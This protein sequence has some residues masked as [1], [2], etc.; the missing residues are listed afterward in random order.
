MNERVA[1]RGSQDPK[2]AAATAAGAE[3][4]AF[5]QIRESAQ[6]LRT[7]G[8]SDEACELL[9]SALEAVLAKSRDLELLVAKLRRQPIGRKSER[10]DPAQLQL[11]FMKMAELP[12]PPKASVDPEAEA[13]EDALLD[14]EIEQAEAKRPKSPGKQ[15]KKGAGWEA[16]GIERQ[17]HRVGVPAADRKCS[18]CG[19][20]MKPL[21][22]DVTRRLEYMPGH[23]IE[24]ETHLETLA[25]PRCKE[26]VITAPAPPQVLERSAVGASVLADMIVGKFIDHRPLHQ[27]SRGYARLGVDI[28]VSTLADW[29]A[30]AGERIAPLVEHLKA[31]VLAATFVRTDATGLLVLDPASPDHVVRGS[32]W[33]YVGDDRDVLFQYTP[34]GKGETGPWTFLAGRKGYIQAD[35][36]N[37]FDR[38][39][40]GEVAKAIEL[41]CWSHAR[42][43]LVAMEDTDCRVAYPL[44]LIARVYRVE[45]LADARGLS[46]RGRATLRQERS[47]PVLEKLQSWFT[48]TRESEPPSTDLAKAAAYSL[49]HWTALTRFLEDGRIS[50]D[51]SL[52][53]QQM[54]AIAQGRKTYLFAGSHAAAARAADFYSLARTCLQYR[55][56][57]L[58]YFTDVL[59]KLAAGWAGDRLDKLLPHWWRGP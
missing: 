27:L 44:K 42:R 5:R 32:M 37:V 52:C 46:P 13:R 14:R 25:C 30:R 22:G 9:L 59:R 43:K 8:H 50:P 45:H 57:P 36:S 11:L 17:V 10:I 56:P 39:F 51:N 47:G 48:A 23:F 35:A 34:T 3:L 24:H 31:R 2:R 29:M 53:E 1:A 16:R 55:V 7:K 28:P 12:A 58:P 38:L 20:E 19:R 41:G 4:P 49:N 40:N 54:R 15:R 21:H 26:D 18:K 6:V 33:A